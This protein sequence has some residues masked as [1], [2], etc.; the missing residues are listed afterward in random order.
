MR[1]CGQVVYETAEWGKYR[2]RGESMGVQ[3]MAFDV[4]GDDA[5]DAACRILRMMLSHCPEKLLRCGPRW[6]RCD[7]QRAARFLRGCADGGVAAVR[8]WQAAARA[9]SR[10]GDHCALPADN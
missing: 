6:A 7:N 9:E 10:G 3:V 8:A 5:V 1:S 4:V 2:R